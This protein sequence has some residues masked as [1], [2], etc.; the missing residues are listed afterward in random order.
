MLSQRGELSSVEQTACGELH[1]KSTRLEKILPSR[2]AYSSVRSAN[3]YMQLISVR[4]LRGYKRYVCVCGGT[5]C[6]T[7]PLQRAEPPHENGHTRSQSREHRTRSED[8]K[9]LAPCSTVRANVSLNLQS[10]N[11]LH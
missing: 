11:R 6:P 10:S 5:G 4:A 1:T 7:E 9:P 8:D 2:P 3:T